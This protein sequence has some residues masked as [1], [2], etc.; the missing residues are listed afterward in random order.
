MKWNF[1]D[2][3]QVVTFSS[4]IMWRTVKL[5]NIFWQK[6]EV[7]ASCACSWA[8]GIQFL[9]ASSIVLWFVVLMYLSWD[10]PQN[11]L[12]TWAWAIAVIIVISVLHTAFLRLCEDLCKAVPWTRSQGFVLKVTETYFF[13]SNCLQLFLYSIKKGLGSDTKT[14]RASNSCL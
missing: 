13:F 4:Q 6:W 5:A 9:L 7:V 8:S 11:K 12:D 1:Q 3:Y 14:L 10:L 2:Y